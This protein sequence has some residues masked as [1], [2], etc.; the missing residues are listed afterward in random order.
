ML[1]ANVS[2]WKY[3]KEKN[4]LH[5]SDLLIDSHIFQVSLMKPLLIRTIA[6]Q[7]FLDGQSL[8]KSSDIY[9]SIHEVTLCAP[10]WNHESLRPENENTIPKYNTNNNSHLPK[11]IF[12]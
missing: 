5:V 4:S 11:C 6:V 3:D 1:D 2:A 12:Y 8:R 7:L 9:R 10:G